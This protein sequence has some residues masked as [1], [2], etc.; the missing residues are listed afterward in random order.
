MKKFV[1]MTLLFMASSLA[2]AQP[3]TPPGDKEYLSDLDII[4]SSTNTCP[5]YGSASDYTYPNTEIKLNYMHFTVT[6]GSTSARQ[7]EGT[8]NF[9]ANE[10]E[11]VHLEVYPMA[12]VNLTLDFPS[13]G[14]QTVVAELKANQWN[15][16]N[17]DFAEFGVTDL[18]AVGN[19]R[20]RSAEANADFYV[21]NYYYHHGVKPAGPQT[22]PGDPEYKS[23]Q[24]IICSKTGNSIW[25]GGYSGATVSSYTYPGTTTEIKYM[26]ME[27]P[28]NGY[29]KETTKF[30]FSTN[31]KEYVHIEIW[32]QTDVKLSMKLSSGGND[33]T[34]ELTGGQWNSFDLDLAD[35][36]VTNLAEVGSVRFKALDDN[37]ADIYVDNYYFHH[38]ETPPEDPKLVVGEPDEE[39]V[40]LVTGPITVET[41]TAF[42]TEIQDE[43]YKGIV[44]YN[45]EGAD[46]SSFPGG[47]SFTTRWTAANPNALFGIKWVAN[48]YA[49]RFV[50]KTNVGFA[51]TVDKKF[52]RFGDVVFTD[53]YDM[54]YPTYSIGTVGGVTPEESV[55]SYS[56]DNITA[57]TTVV[58]PF[59]ATVP[60]GVS[61]YEFSATD[62]TKNELTFKPV[63]EME[64]FKPYIIVGSALN[65][66]TT[67]NITQPTPAEVEVA[68]DVKLTGTFQAIA[69]TT[70]EDNIYMLTANG[71]TL[72]FTQSV[73]E[74]IGAFRAYLKLGASA[75]AGPFTVVLSDGSVTPPEEPK[76]VVGEPDEEGVA[77]VTGPI[78]VE[79]VTA[80]LTEIQNE[81]YKGIVFYNLEGAN[82][83]AFPGG[84]AFTTRWTAANPNALFGIKWVANTYA[85][86]F[87]DKTNVGFANT[88][89]KKFY[90]FGD[91]VFTDGYDML[92]PTYSIGTVS[93][94]TPEES[95]I[96]YSRD[97]IT[98]ATT[99]VLPF[100]ATVPEGVSA[101]EFSAADLTKNELTFK[102][103]AEMEAFKPYI[104]VGSALNVSTTAN[105][106]QP[107]PAEVEVA[108]D[109]KL[110][111][112]FQA[113]ATTTAE[114]N[115]YM[116]TANGE[117]LQFTQSV[118]EAIG[119]FRSYLKLGAS[120]A[121]GPFT[122]VLYKEEPTGVKAIAHGT[123]TMNN[124][125]FDLQGRCVRGHLSKGLYVINGKKVVVK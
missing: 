43:K 5:W 42:L 91:V 105:I 18:S 24:D 41:V 38:R 107:T 119:A 86:R 26:H 69:T 111:G 84:G 44:F 82:Y 10:K 31:E 113:I 109:V 95:S 88:V 13:G 34:K 57:A 70:A 89:D 104:I 23:D 68:T 7:W 62:L 16:L 58:L 98:A 20:F 25:F 19:L 27:M 46:Y 11:F 36:G 71:E 65:V 94:V 124:T 78:T 4:C 120:A 76:L 56:R 17:Y 49:N 2:W 3:Q 117:T 90:R 22:P 118:G 29:T 63:A 48:T 30:N 102:P 80:F 47:G 21:D 12:D 67:A 64:A 101:Y 97:N 114:D 77:L 61:A 99:V 85:N 93:G 75:A 50:D 28:K 6:Q 53:G 103:V 83:D 8:N 33:L 96:S 106:T 121:A 35:F 45:L 59:T 81:K 14:S 116:L 60:E 110:T 1:S 115:I 92:Y 9:S 122:V 125:A 100:T 52:Y 74:G 123:E 15:S 79:T 39:G 108:T 54:L 51:N 112:T 72:Q 87:V 66:S 40:S 32:T 73:G 37:G 55:I